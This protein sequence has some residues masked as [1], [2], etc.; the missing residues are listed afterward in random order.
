MHK[1]A[2]V[3]YNKNSHF[4]DC[5]M[6]RYAQPSAL[7]VLLESLSVY[8][9]GAAQNCLLNT[10]WGGSSFYKV[11]FLL[12]TT[13]LTL[14]APHADCSRTGQ[15]RTP[16][17]QCAESDSHYRKLLTACGAPLPHAPQPS[18]TYSPS[19]SKQ[20][21]GRARHIQLPLLPVS[22]QQHTPKVV[23]PCK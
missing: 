21:Y 5:P 15:T 23:L 20:S 14:P 6:Y 3:L 8:E 11:I 10:S 1:G 12:V 7:S 16:A 13:G 2:K 4:S 17:T 18:L 19:S 9:T 22:H